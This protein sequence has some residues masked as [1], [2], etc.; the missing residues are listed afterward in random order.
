MGYSMVS[1]SNDLVSTP[2]TNTQQSYIEATAKASSKHIN[3][4]NLP[5]NKPSDLINNTF[6]NFNLGSRDS[7]VQQSLNTLSVT[8]SGFLMNDLPDNNLS[9]TP[10]K[11]Q[12]IHHIAHVEEKCTARNDKMPSN[13]CLIGGAYNND[14]RM[15][16]GVNYLDKMS[17]VNQ[18]NSKMDIMSVTQMD[19]SMHVSDLS[20]NGMKDNSGNNVIQNKN[21]LTSL[22]ELFNKRDNAISNL[23]APSG[24]YLFGD[25]T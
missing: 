23:F 18:S 12:N 6:S 1:T 10:S 7:L 4:L 11:A 3:A 17:V 21:M 5:P 25:C 14:G 15:S 16:M 24:V 2:F 13:Q 22:I 9:I 19:T 20:S 8:S